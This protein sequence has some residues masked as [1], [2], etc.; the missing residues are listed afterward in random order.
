MKLNVIVHYCNLSIQE[1]EVGRV[2][3]KGLGLPCEFQDNL[4]YVVKP[5]LKK[6]NK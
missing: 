4:G 6:I 2:G 1:A 5:C 3:F